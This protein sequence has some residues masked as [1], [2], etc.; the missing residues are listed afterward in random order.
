MPIRTPFSTY[1]S[2]HEKRIIDAERILFDPDPGRCY[3]QRHRHAKQSRNP[4]VTGMV[5]W[6]YGRK[7]I[8]VRT[9]SGSMIVVH[10]T[11]AE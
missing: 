8:P 11:N 7:A 6:C 9:L 10:F 1:R 4:D 5:V 3:E 2:S